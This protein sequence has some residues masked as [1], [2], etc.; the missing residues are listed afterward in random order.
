MRGLVLPI[1]PQRPRIISVLYA[2]FILIFAAWP[3]ETGAQKLFTT[4]LGLQEGQASANTSATPKPQKKKGLAPLRNEEAPE[5]SRVTITYNEPLS[6][7][8]AYRQ[9]DRFVV[10]IPKSEA[11]RVRSNMRGRGFDGVQVEKRGED[12]VLSFRI[13]PGVKAR[14]A[15]QFNRLEV[16]FSAPGQAAA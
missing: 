11:P 4:P 8:S 7:Y 16:V 1:P 9:G 13:Q 3:L 2:L 14:V 6:D 15:Q 5:G 12:T 10:V